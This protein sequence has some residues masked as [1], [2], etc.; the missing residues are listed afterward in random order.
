M[1][2]QPPETSPPP[3]AL[4]APPLEDDQPFSV[5]DYLVVNALFIGFV[6]V[7]YVAMLSLFPD[8][9]GLTFFFAVIIFGFIG[10]SVY[11]YLFDRLSGPPGDG[12]G[13]K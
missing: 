11:D 5:A 1:A 8:T 7:L 6:L 3:D 13:P 12:S 10:V 2:E 4:P 9:G